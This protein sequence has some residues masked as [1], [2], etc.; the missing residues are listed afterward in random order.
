MKRARLLA[1]TAAGF[2]L[3]AILI[4]TLP[5]AAQMAV[6]DTN[7]INQTIQQSSILS[8]IK[9]VMT[10]MN[11]TISDVKAYANDI[12]CAL[13]DN[14]FGIVQQLLQEGFTQNANYS[15][16]QV[17][18]WQ[19]ITDASNLANSQFQMQMRQAVIRDD[20]TVSPNNCAALDG[21]VST[22]AAAVQGYDVAWTIANIHNARGEAQPGMPSYYG[23]AQGVASMAAEHI[24]NYCDQK[25]VDAGLCSAVSPTPDADATFSSLYGSGTYG[26]QQAINAAKDYAVNLIEPVAPAALRGGQLSSIAGQDAA[27]RRRSFDARM[28]LAQSVVDQQIGMQTPSVP[29]TQAQQQYLTNMGL[30]T[31]TDGNISWFQALQ[32]EAERRVS[33]VGWAA[34]LHEEPPVAVEREIAQELALTNY[35]A[36]QNF[37]LGLQHVDISASLLAEQTGRDFVPITTIPTP[38]ISAN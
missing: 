25:D 15:K 24:A 18:A 7:E 14:T 16:A 5:A 20:H 9:D 19:Q 34:T 2:I 8:A 6:I 33:D 17:G 30:P 31:P 21:G 11:S 10:T 29:I 22:E 12:F 38:S 28:S 3:G 23:Q 36:F 1:S 37:K 13:G 27:V 32:I 26:T 35:L 4:N